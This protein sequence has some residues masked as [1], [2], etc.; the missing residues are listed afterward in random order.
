[1]LYL[2]S[3]SDSNWTMPEE[4]EVEE[5]D[6]RIRRKAIFATNG[7]G[8]DDDASSSEEDEDEDDEEEDEEELIAG[9]PKK[10]SKKSQQVETAHS[11]STTMI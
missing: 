6:G 4:D 7:V 2:T 3:F 5:K 11:Y 1:M 10:K 8:Q 9:T